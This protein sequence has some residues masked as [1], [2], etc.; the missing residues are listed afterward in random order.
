MLREAV[1]E[2]SAMCLIYLEVLCMLE[3]ESLK[4]MN[5]LPITSFHQIKSRFSPYEQLMYNDS[6]PYMIV[7]RSLIQPRFLVKRSPFL[8]EYWSYELG[9]NLN[10][11]I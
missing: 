5:N 4:M 1:L 6:L 10:L 7:S 8:C 3:W 2:A 11:I 9:V